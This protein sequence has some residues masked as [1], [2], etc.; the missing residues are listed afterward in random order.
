[1]R[2]VLNTPGVVLCRSLEEMV[3]GVR[4]ILDGRFLPL[5]AALRARAGQIAHN[6]DGEASQRIVMVL[7]RLARGGRP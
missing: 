5:E 2:D 6:L 3:E 1:M 7:E 4:A